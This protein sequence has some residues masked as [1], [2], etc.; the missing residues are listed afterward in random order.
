[1]RD[2]QEQL[3]DNRLTTVEILYHLPDHPLL[4][5]SYVWQTFDRAPDYPRLKRFLEYWHGHIEAKLPSV[6]LASG[7]R[8]RPA[9]VRV[10]GSTHFLH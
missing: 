7:K 4:L 5:Q 6:K 2:I 10:A 8:I 3:N 9:R 1:M